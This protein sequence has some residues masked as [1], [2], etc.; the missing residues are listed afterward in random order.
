[1]ENPLHGFSSVISE[2]KDWAK[3][4]FNSDMGLFRWFLFTG[5]ILVLVILWTMVLRDL[6]GE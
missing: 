6:K 1:M 4:P 5:L 3:S 2:L